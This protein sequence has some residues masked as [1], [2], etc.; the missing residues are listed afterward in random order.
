[1]TS[2]QVLVVA[3][4]DWNRAALSDWNF[5]DLSF[6]FVQ[7]F[8]SDGLSAWRTAHTTAGEAVD[9]AA[10]CYAYSGGYAQHA[11]N[12][13]F[14]QALFRCRPRVVVVVGLT[15]CTIDL[16]RLADLLG[17]PALLILD[18]P[19]EP[20]D[21]L[22][23]ATR[24]W[25][26]SSLACSRHILWAQAEAE[27]SW[28]AHW[29][30]GRTVARMDDLEALLRRVAE[31]PV[32][33]R[34]N[35]Y[36]MYEFCQRDHPLLVNMQS[37]DVRHFQG[38]SRVLDVACGVGIFLD[39]LRQAGM[40]GEGVERD[41]QVAAYARGMGLKVST[42]DVLTYLQQTEVSF[43][44]MYCSHFVEH[45]PM[46]SV[47]GLLQLMATR[48]AVGGV[49]VLVFPDPESIRSQLL[50]FW[51]D[52]EHVRFYH[53][54]LIISM[55]ASSGLE[56]EWSSYSEQ[57]HRV[58]PFEAIPLP[59]PQTTPLP[60]LASEDD[61]AGFGLGEKLL[62]MFGFV[63]QRRLGDLERRLANWSNALEQRSRQYVEAT[64]QLEA[65][66]SAL[67]DVNQTWAWND[68]VTLRFRKSG[69][70]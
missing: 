68:N 52:P 57:P 7:E 12:R 53:P 69:S 29:L 36:S 45:L 13:F 61:H 33:D 1:M 4:A 28:P 24:V 37:A 34:C 27:H 6:Q 56:L 46:K 43:D 10:H 60:A 30:I 66:T 2:H 70:A 51:R 47:Q 14:A 3:P 31:E 8:P 50:G 11:L 22:S 15:G 16:L 55:A 39:C 64:K 58:V 17:I 35:D 9:V 23:E 38:A 25:L 67:W 21:A 48:A 32:T 19:A 41:P 62:Q 5:Y 44:G 42:L 59:V 20:P 26:E 40:Q 49:V 18:T 65:R 63:S 54:E